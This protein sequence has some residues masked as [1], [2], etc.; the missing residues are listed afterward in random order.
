MKREPIVSSNIRS[1]GF[2]GGEMH[3]EFTNGRVYSYTGPRVH[4]HY[5]AIM[6]S[7]SAGKYFAQHIRNDPETKATA[8]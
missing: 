6:K 3:I 2:E 5:Q 7:E 1:I 4:E 8:L